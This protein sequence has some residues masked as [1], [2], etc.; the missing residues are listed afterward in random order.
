MGSSDQKTIRS[1][2]F[3]LTDYRKPPQEDGYPD[4]RGKEGEIT[5]IGA[6]SLARRGE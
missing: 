3:R 2:V 1:I 4:K 6:W 5:R